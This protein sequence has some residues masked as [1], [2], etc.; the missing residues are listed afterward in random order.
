MMSSPYRYYRPSTVEKAA[1]SCRHKAP[2]TYTPNMNGTATIP[3]VSLAWASCPRWAVRES[4][5][6]VD[7]VEQPAGQTCAVLI[8]IQGSGAS[9]RRLG[10]A[11][12]SEA[13]SLLAGG[14]AADLAAHV[15]NQLLHS[16]RDGQV[17][18]T[19][20][21]ASI[22][23]A[24]C[25]AEIAGYGDATIAVGDETGWRCHELRGV[26]AG[27]DPGASPDRRVVGLDEDAVVIISSD[28][29]AASANGLSLLLTNLSGGSATASIVS[30][31][32]A[33]A[34]ERDHG[35][36]SSDMATVA[37]RIGFEEPGVAIDR[38]EILRPLRVRAAKS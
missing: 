23:P 24:R 13:R 18:A 30:G 6:L 19:I 9:P 28:G 36:P 37:L 16:W 21:V 3:H 11:L 31:L 8:D 15:L 22:A 1:R 17:G 12:K 10:Q 38:G 5:D 27:H 32:I 33:A 20:V 4:A 7:I 26:L 25:R 35:R 29:L 2:E 14:V 34:I